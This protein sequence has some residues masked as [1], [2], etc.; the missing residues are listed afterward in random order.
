MIEADIYVPKKG[1]GF[2]TEIDDGSGIVGA[3]DEQG[4]LVIHYEGN[5]IG[6][7]NLRTWRERVRCAAG[8][9]F[10]SYP[11][12]AM[13]LVPPEREGELEKVGRIT[14]LDPRSVYE[15][16]V[17]PEALPALI[18]YS[19]QAPDELVEWKL[20]IDDVDSY[21][22]DPKTVATVFNNLLGINFVSQ[23]EQER[24][25]DRVAG[26]FDVESSR[27]CGP[28]RLMCNGVVFAQGEVGERDQTLRVTEATT[29]AAL[30]NLMNATAQVQSEP[31]SRLKP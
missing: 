15:I 12:I 30:D 23:I 3:R 24:W 17:N 31:S 13:Q 4:R 18:E 1:S 27:L 28:V 5:R 10:L 26:F 9:K 16:T 20:V 21:T 11:T 14:S 7:E 22:G 8:R 25:L 19:G 2:E 6:A 29:R